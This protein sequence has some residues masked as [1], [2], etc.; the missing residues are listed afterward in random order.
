VRRADYPPHTPPFTCQQV[1]N[2][3]GHNTI[4]YGDLGLL[5]KLGLLLR[6]PNPAVTGGC[7][8]GEDGDIQCRI[9][10]GAT[11]YCKVRALRSGR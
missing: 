10:Y 1:P 5:A 6:F 11:S 8:E 7:K 4:D 3:R 2:A 9:W